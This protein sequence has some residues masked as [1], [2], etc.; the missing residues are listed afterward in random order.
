LDLLDLE[1][2]K[3]YNLNPKNISENFDEYFAQNKLSLR[4]AK[5]KTGTND[6]KVLAMTISEM[7][8]QKAKRLFFKIIEQKIENWI[9]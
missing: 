3:P 1:P 9:D 8:H 6:K 7:K 5:L 2:D 4:K